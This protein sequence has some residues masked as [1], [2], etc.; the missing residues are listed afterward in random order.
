MKRPIATLVVM[1]ILIGLCA[2]S[3]TQPST[4]TTGHNVAPTN[5]P[6]ACS[7]KYEAAV[8]KAATC[9]EAGETTYICSA[10]GDSY[11]EQIN[12]LDHELAD[13]KC[14]RCGLSLVNYSPVEDSTWT[15]SLGYAGG[16]TYG[17][18]NFDNGAFIYS[19]YRGYN[20]ND[21]DPDEQES[22]LQRYPDQ[23][24][25]WGNFI[26]QTITLTGTYTVEG[27]IITMVFQNENNTT[28][29]LKRESEST[30]DD[31]NRAGFDLLG[32]NLNLTKEA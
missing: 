16:F 5:T 22:L 19:E 2:C 8:T 27:D 18:V 21:L 6:N 20:I 24:D 9:T 11:T 13:G 23:I 28:I 25:E 14:T 31:I 1:L 26:Q 12:A 29:L 15:F 7:H 4:P 10:C 32:H 17:D 30:I 3:N